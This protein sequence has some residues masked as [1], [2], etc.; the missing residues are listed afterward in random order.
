MPWKRLW[1]RA[2]HKKIPKTFFEI[3]L[4]HLRCLHALDSTC[5]S[6]R[7]EKKFQKKFEKFIWCLQALRSA[8]DSARFTKNSKKKFWNFFQNTWGAYMPRIALCLRV[9]RQ[10]IPKKF[11]NFFSCLLALGSAC[12]STRFT[13]KF[14]KHFLKF[15]SKYLKCLHALDSACVSVWFA[16]KF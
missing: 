10:K 16:K 13:K 11:W 4:I 6:V 1:L 15:F 9:V 8:C 2:V 3:F 12:D 7:F 14:Q 5:V